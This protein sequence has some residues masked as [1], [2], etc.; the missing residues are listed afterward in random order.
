[1]L[2]LFVTLIVCSI[3]GHVPQEEEEEEEEKKKKK[4]QEWYRTVNS[5]F[6]TPRNRLALLRGLRGLGW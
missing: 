2:R 3:N 6:F 1:M 4:R 5:N